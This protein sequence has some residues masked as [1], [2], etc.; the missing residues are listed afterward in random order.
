MPEGDPHF[1]CVLYSTIAS[2]IG[3]LAGFAGVG[4]FLYIFSKHS[5]R[6]TVIVAILAPVIVHR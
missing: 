4:A 2:I 6:F 3:S 5:Y 1:T